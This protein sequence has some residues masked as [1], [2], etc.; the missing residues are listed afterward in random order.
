MEAN[1]V[2]E[3]IDEFYNDLYGHDETNEVIVNIIK[4]DEQY[5]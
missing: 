5:E 3:L 4:L 2:N 1:N